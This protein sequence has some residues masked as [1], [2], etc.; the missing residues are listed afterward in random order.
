MLYAVAL[1]LLLAVLLTVLAIRRAD[2]RRRGLRLLAGLLAAA[3]L[4][5]AAFPPTRS[6]TQPAP[7]SAI[8]L[9]DG[10]SPDTLR[11]LQR[12]VAAGTPVWRLASHRADDTTTIPNVAAV[13]QLLPGITRLHVLGQ[14][15]PVADVAALQGL[16][17]VPHA[18]AS[19]LGFAMAAWP[20]QPE[21]GQPWQIEGSF[22]APTSGSVWV[23][24]LAAGAPRDSV[25]LPAGRGSFRLRFTPKAV[26]TAVYQVQAYQTGRLLS[27]EPVPVEILPTQPLRLLIL[28]SAPSFEI[29]FLKDE[30][31]ARQ[32]QVALRIGVSRGLAQTEFLNLPAP[33]NL[34][35][36][37]PRLLAAFDVVL[38][39]TDALASLSAD[40]SQALSQSVRTSTCNVLLLAD[41]SAIPRQ[42]PGGAAFRLQ[43]RPANAA[44]LPLQW[45]GT[46]QPAPA[47]ATHV[48]LNS[49]SL[50]PLLSTANQQVAAASRRLGLGQVAV[51]TVTE[52]FP[53]LL[54]RQ[55]GVYHAYWSQLLSAVRPAQTNSE[56]RLLSSWPRPAE[57]VV[58]RYE[59]PA[60]RN[61]LT[62]ISPR[63]TTTLVRRQD[64][65]VPEWT[66]APYW[67]AAPGWHEA[68]VGS[69][70]RHFYVY[71]AMAWPLPR[72]AE[73]Q[74]AA[75]QNAAMG[76][77]AV[78]GAPATATTTWP[79]WLGF[80]LFVL[81]AGLLWVEE[82]I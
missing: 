21:L 74:R 19:R 31:A 67:A 61:P 51:T 40:E 64:A 44:A 1:C 12:Q 65:A 26:G 22:S 15:L 37:T 41:G 52:T 58:L 14:G 20:T 33:L 73:W 24:L 3:G 35:R 42:L 16:L 38:L 82:K 63:N 59:G 36:L 48:L 56:L 78:V 7:A 79:R 54:Q 29:R 46:A 8:L 25:Q 75:R 80:G 62:I 81:G 9:T 49:A 71:D 27:Q 10:Y 6:F 32:H 72:F 30:L 4:I 70:S 57:P 34:S 45:P 39:D 53:W 68:R 17:L 13:R 47:P 60:T 69:T 18:D 50:R 28:A 77:Q 11:A 76:A 43:A 55:S 66:T 5:L 2:T 23:R